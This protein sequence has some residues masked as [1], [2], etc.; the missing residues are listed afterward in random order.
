MSHLGRLPLEFG[1][2]AILEA[3]ER[4]KEERAWQLWLARSQWKDIGPF[5]QF[6]QRTPR[7]RKRVG[8]KRTAEE[9]LAEA[10]RIR[11]AIQQRQQ[12]E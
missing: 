3:L 9:M 11:D 2:E 6:Y 12:Q 5:G 10:K 8:K 4:R 7:M 1:V